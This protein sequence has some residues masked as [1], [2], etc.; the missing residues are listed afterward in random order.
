MKTTREQK[1]EHK[2]KRRSP[3]P[4][5]TP[6]PGKL[7]KKK[8]KTKPFHVV[9]PTLWGKDPER[10]IT[11][12]RAATYQHAVDYIEKTRRGSYSDTL[13]T[14]LGARRNFGDRLFVRDIRA[15]VPG[16]NCQSCRPITMEDMRMVLCATCG[17]KRCPHANDH[18]LPCTKSNLPGQLGSAYP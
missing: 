4:E 6:L 11:W 16:C 1:V 18:R 2:N 12:H 3:A 14:A 13:M 17:N 8:K 5:K 7:V 9:G 15:Y 10:I